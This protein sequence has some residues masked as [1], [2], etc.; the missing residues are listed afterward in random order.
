MIGRRW[1]NS[2]VALVAIVAS[3]SGA[4]AQDYPNRPVRIIV[5]SVPGS[6][7]DV[8]A[9]I[10]AERVAPQLKR[11]SAALAGIPTIGDSIPGFSAKTWFG[12]FAP[13][14]TRP[15]VIARLNRDV[16]AVLE[17]AATRQALALQGLVVE[18]SEPAALAELVRADIARYKT[19]AQ[20][21]K[22]EAN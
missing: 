22:I 15:D 3:S 9:R 17:S 5:A 4:Y 7:P 11:P 12:L 1:V 6:A 8:L 13:A 19:L 2:T 10:L 18:T 20:R 21:L 14:G 16:R